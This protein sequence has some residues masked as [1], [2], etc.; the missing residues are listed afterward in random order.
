MEA[1]CYS[2]G[3]GRTH[4]IRFNASWRDAVIT[5]S[6][7]LLVGLLLYLNGLNVDQWLMDWTVS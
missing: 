5:I 7:A 4:L 3:K 1:R 2:G 6:T